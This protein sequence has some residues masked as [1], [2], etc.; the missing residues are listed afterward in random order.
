M[1]CAQNR[2]K[3]GLMAEIIKERPTA[4]WLQ[5]LDAND[6]PSAPVLRRNEVIA[7]EQVLARELIVELD[8]PDIGGSAN[9]FPPPV[10]TVPPREFKGRRRALAS[11]ARQSWRS[12]DWKRLRSNGWRPK[13]SCAWSRPSA[14]LDRNHRDTRD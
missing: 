1:V 9:P 10:L 13:R 6:V 12:S 4:E 8:H 14:L 5:R 3:F 7:N 11:T 2:A